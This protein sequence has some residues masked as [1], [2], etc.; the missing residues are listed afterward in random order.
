MG[1][2]HHSYYDDFSCQYC[3]FGGKTTKTDV[4]AH[5]KAEHPQEKLFSCETCP[6]KSNYMVNLKT[7]RN[8]KHNKETLECKKCEWTTTWR[9][10]Y[11]EHM[12]FK[13]GV[14]Q[15]NAKHKK[16]LEFFK[17]VCDLCNF[18]ATSELSMRLHMKSQC[19][20]TTVCRANLNKIH[21]ISFRSRLITWAL[22]ETLS[23]I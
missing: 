15:R 21:N 22:Y 10:A 4:V 19:N 13:H 6:Y 17:S 7:H 18:S 9:N 12:R 3:T 20:M 16:D 8:A 1:R 11:S 2:I 23:N 14:F 5:M